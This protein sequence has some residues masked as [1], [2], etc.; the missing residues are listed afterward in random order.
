MHPK[1]VVAVF[2]HADVIKAAAAHYAGIHLDL[3]Q[4]LVIDTASV[5]WIRFTPH[6]PRIIRVND[7]G[8]LEPPKPDTGADSAAKET[9]EEKETQE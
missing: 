6:G 9:P 2:S 7:S 8:D 3:F 4:R 5:T 1:G